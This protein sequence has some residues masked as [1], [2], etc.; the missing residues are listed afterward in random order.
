MVEI[1]DKF[2]CFLQK[3]K[4]A[5]KAQPIV[6]TLNCPSDET[7]FSLCYEEKGGPLSQKYMDHIVTCKYCATFVRI[8][9]QYKID[10]RDNLSNVNYY[11]S[12]TTIKIPYF[13]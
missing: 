3:V 13:L 2:E 6:R 11:F 8:A 9:I 7:L 5:Y 10:K 12:S 4:K 1:D